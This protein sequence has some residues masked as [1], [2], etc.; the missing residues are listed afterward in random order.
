LT[1][2]VNTRQNRL[3]VIKRQET[4]R[5]ALTLCRTFLWTGLM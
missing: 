1:F 5:L 2:P 3:K 4:P